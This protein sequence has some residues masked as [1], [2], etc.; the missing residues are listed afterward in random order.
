VI[1]VQ[2]IAQ[3]QDF[4][5]LVND[6]GTPAKAYGDSRK[7]NAKAI[8]STE[9]GAAGVGISWPVET[10]FDGRLAVNPEL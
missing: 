9:Y 6:D 2:A 10:C 8:G 5:L 3:E 7:G 1:L 4:Q